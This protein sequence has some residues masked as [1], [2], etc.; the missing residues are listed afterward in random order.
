MDDL[1][2]FASD[3][4]HTDNGCAILAT[5]IGERVSGSI[6]ALLML[7]TA[8]LVLL[9]GGRLFLMI[10]AVTFTY[11]A[12]QAMR[13]VNLF[14]LVSGIVLTANLGGWVSD[15]AQRYGDQSHRRGRSS[16][17][18]PWPARLHRRFDRIADL[19]CRHRSVLCAVGDPPRFG[20]GEAPLA[21]AHDA[22]RFA[23]RAGMP[24]R[25]VAYDLKEAGVYIYHNFPQRKVFVDGRLRVPDGANVRHVRLDRGQAQRRREEAGPSR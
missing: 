3:W 1:G 19:Q 9:R 25:A 23:G 8:G 12:L 18:L 2:A 16:R 22:A 4:A 11:L 17:S 13:N 10:I 24:G 20:F 15:T 21:Y 5:N 14:G 7:A 6:A